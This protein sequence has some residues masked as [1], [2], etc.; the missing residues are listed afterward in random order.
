MIGIVAKLKTKEGAEAD[1]EAV[2]KQL[3]EAVNANEPNCQYYQLFRS[4]EPQTYLMIEGYDDMAAVENHR[5]TDHFKTIGR[6]MGAHMAGPPE[7]QIL[8]LVE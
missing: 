5:S 3:V 8:N 4:E 1:F 6:A 7:V 2:A